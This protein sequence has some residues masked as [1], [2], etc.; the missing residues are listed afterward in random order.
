MKKSMV[1][2]RELCIEIFNTEGKIISSGSTEFIELNIKDYVSDYTFLL[3]NN[4]FI[5]FEFQTTYN[6]IGNLRRFKL[7]EAYLE[8]TNKK[9]I[10]TYVIYSN[11]I[12]YPIN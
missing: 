12:T 4:T 10:V 8:Y 3:Y 6:G 11:D 5:N 9:N 1:T 2:F 7:Y